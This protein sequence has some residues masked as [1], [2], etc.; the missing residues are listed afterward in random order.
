[1]NTTSPTPL[2]EDSGENAPREGAP[3]IERNA[4]T[5]VV[6]DLRTDRIL[7]LRWDNDADWETLITGG[8]EE[9]QTPEEACVTE[10]AQETGYKNVELV[11]EL[12][13]YDSKF[14]HH[15]KKVN[16]YAH[17]R[18]FLFRLKGD[19]K[20]EVSEDELKIHVPVWLTREEMEKFHLPEGH[21]YTLRNAYERIG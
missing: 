12:P 5:A 20:D 15:D 9:G 21:R 14:Y 1:M 17:F 3:W 4:I 16:R 8:I 18:C 6:H 10:I 2:F 7:G 13:P 11:A 19:E